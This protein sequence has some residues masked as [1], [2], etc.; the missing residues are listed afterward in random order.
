MDY[1]DRKQQK[2]CLLINTTHTVLY[3]YSLLCVFI[4][5]YSSIVQF[6]SMGEAQWGQ[7]KTRDQVSLPPFG[8]ATDCKYVLG[9]CLFPSFNPSPPIPLRLYTLPYWSNPP[10]FN[11]WHSG[12]LA[13]R[14]ECQRAR[15]SKIKNGGL[16]Q[17]S[18][19]P[20]EQQQ[21]GTAGVEGVKVQW[22]QMLH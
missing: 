13:L 14:T 8:V 21:F 7:S 5:Q 17:Y 19:E 1:C 11:F 4:S 6:I 9:V 10:F 15:M 18:T 16:D 12:A 22:H 2:Q 20:F 3:M